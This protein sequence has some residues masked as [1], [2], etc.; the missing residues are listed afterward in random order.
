M[1]WLLPALAWS[2]TGVAQDGGVVSERADDLARDAQAIIE[3][4]PEQ[5]DYSDQERCIPAHRIREINV[6]DEKHIEFVMLAKQ[7]YLVQLKHRC[8]GLRRGFPVIYEPS[9][10]RLCATDGI[11]ATYR[12]MGGGYQ[13]GMRCA[14]DGFQEVS[15]EQLVALKDAL[16]A[17]KR[18]RR[19]EKRQRREE[20]RQQRRE[21]NQTAQAS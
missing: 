2:Q 13:P 17:E 10:R 16:Q 9:G 4:E 18:K 19:Q 11:R 12:G 14:L 20:K 1:L 7:Y 21:Q 6:I 15:K 8:P 3:R 5:E